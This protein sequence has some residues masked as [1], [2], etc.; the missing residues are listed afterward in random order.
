MS[1]ATVSIKSFKSLSIT[2]LAYTV[3]LSSLMPIGRS[4]E[5]RPATREPINYKKLGPVTSAASTASA[6]VRN[7]LGT[8]PIAFEANR[9]QSDSRVKFLSRG[10]G[11]TLLLTST[12]AV[13]NL[14]RPVKELDRP[15]KENVAHAPRAGSSKADRNKLRRAEIRMTFAGA[16][17][18]PRMEG[19]DQQSRKVNY[20]IGKDPKKWRKGV[21]NYSKVKYHQV[22]S[23]IDLV[24]YGNGQQLEYD[25][26]VAPGGDPN[27]IRMEFK[28]ADKLEVDGQGDLVLYTAAGVVHHRKPLIFQEVNGKRQQVTGRFAQRGKQV[29]FEVGDY[30]RTKAL[31]IDP[32]IAYSTL[33]GGSGY[34]SG[35]SAF[36][37]ATHTTPDGN[38]YVYVAGHTSQTDFSIRMAMQPASGGTNGACQ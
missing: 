5:K 21:E 23:G 24:Y 14:D 27:K 10:S 12:E 25:F 28:G 32:V 34:G 33:L 18:N 37:I 20:F 22:Y 11:Y 8:I 6:R 9:G 16:N 19:L 2:F 26:V 30:D 38:V 29:G 15:V 3:L 17:S 7:A 36:G 31:V 35:S 13:L 1:Y 4:A